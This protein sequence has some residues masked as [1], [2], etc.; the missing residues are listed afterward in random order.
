M[1][2]VVHQACT[3]VG[4]LRRGGGEGDRGHPKGGKGV[5]AF[6]YLGGGGSGGW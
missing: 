5:E 4:G 6:F 2:R 3:N 1:V